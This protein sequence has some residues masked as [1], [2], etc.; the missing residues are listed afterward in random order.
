M[1]SFIVAIIKLRTEVEKE[2]NARIAEMVDRL[3]NKRF[4]NGKHIKLTFEEMLGR[5]Q[6]IGDIEALL[7]KQMD[8][9]SCA[10]LNNPPLRQAKYST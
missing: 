9:V 5:L 2:F 3:T 1:I 6:S 7:I 4:E 10:K 8:R